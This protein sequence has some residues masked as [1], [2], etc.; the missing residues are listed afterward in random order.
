[1]RV[2]TV[3]AG[4]PNPWQAGGPLMHWA[5]LQALA[6]AGHDV[7]FVSLPW[8]ADQKRTDRIDAVR[9]L[10]VDVRLVDAPPPPPRRGRWAARADYV[11]S[12]V[13]PD[14]DALF[15]TSAF[16]GPLAETIADVAPDVALF[17]APTAIAPARGIAVPKVA[18]FADMPGISR[19]N[20]VRFAPAHPWRLG[21]TELTYRVSQATYALR[22]DERFAAILREFD[23]VAALGPHFA[24]WLRERGVNAWH[25]HAPVA[26]GAGADWRA[27]RASAR[28]GE[29]ARILMIGH[30][31]GISTISGLDVLVRHVLPA[32]TARLGSDAFELRIVG[33]YEPPP[34]LE[35]VLRAHPAVHLPG[36]VEPPDDEFL[37]ADVLLV[38]T[39]IVSGPRVRIVTGMSFGCCIVAHSAHVLGLPELRHG[40]N[41]LLAPSAG[42]ADQTVRALG[43]PGLRERLGANGRE[44]YESLFTPERAGARLVAELERVARA[45]ARATAA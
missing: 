37:S 26:D 9:E 18:M 2:A 40:H 41:V 32:L 34:A 6:D 12:I 10:G 15:P 24:R 22:A 44:L 23:S 43:D 13:W 39:P 8:E 1:M 29:K 17:D 20:R 16:A 21:R 4:V 42:L 5:T 33:G 11:R 25:A 38:P 14:D 27:R 30:L 3:F 45:P 36:Q 31:R 19:R 28:R 35:R 7:T